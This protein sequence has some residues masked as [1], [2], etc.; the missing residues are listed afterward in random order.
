MCLDVFYKCF[1]SKIRMMAEKKMKEKN[2]I[3]KWKPPMTNKKKRK[4]SVFLK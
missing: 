3:K 4:K 2:K 1:Y